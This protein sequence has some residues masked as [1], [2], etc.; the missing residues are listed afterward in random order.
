M[1]HGQERSDKAKTMAT[2]FVACV[3]AQKVIGRKLHME[4][5]SPL[6]NTAT[7]SSYFCPSFSFQ[8]PHS[9]GQTQPSGRSSLVFR[10]LRHGNCFGLRSPA[11]KQASM[12]RSKCR[13]VALTRCLW[14]KAP[15]SWELGF[16]ADKR[17]PWQVTWSAGKGWG[18]GENASTHMQAELWVYLL[19]CHFS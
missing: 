19:E 3:C 12:S 5:P 10:C 1:L 13:V 16:L 15:L 9:H 8:Q 4:A 11:Q 6:A 2:A 14:F 18:N 17:P 7:S